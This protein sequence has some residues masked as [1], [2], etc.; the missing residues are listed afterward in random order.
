MDEQELHAIPKHSSPKIDL[1][2]ELPLRR[3]LPNATSRLHLNISMRIAGPF[4]RTAL[5]YGSFAA[6]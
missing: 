5:H 3:I 4:H 2:Y 6:L 1:H